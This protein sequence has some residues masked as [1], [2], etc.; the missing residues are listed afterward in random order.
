MRF[1]RGVTNA[2]FG[3]TV[4]A[5]LVISAVGYGLYFTN[6]S[7]GHTTTSVST[8]MMNHT[9]NETTTETSTE[10]MMHTESAM[11]FTPASGQTVH[12]A[13]LLVEPTSTGQFAVSIHAEGLQSTQGTGN[14][15][16][17][18][19]TSSSA[20]MTTGLIG[21]N[22]TSSE[23][24]TTSSGV[25]NFFI[26][27]GQNPLTSFESVEIVFLAGMQMSNGQVVATAQLSSAM[28][29]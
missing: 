5:L 17:V 10:V 4:V 25:G 16:A 28:S 1:R 12:S 15:Y 14:V 26:V 18:E 24:E 22:E 7:S 9:M 13:W 2:I 6:A 3:G 29:G 27:L 8:E 21:P 11:G 23:F 19:A 20:A